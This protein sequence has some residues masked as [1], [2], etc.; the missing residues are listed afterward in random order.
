[1][2]TRSSS[3]R[4]NTYGDQN[5]EKA[6]MD[7]DIFE[8]DSS[9]SSQSAR[10]VSERSAYTNDGR[11]AYTNDASTM[12]SESVE[13]T[14]Y[15]SKDF[16]SSD[17]KLMAGKSSDSE[18]SESESAFKTIMGK[19]FTC[20]NTG[21]SKD[22]QTVNNDCD[23]DVSVFSA[24]S[25][26][27][28]HNQL[29]MMTDMSKKLDYSRGTTKLGRIND[30]DD[31]DDVTT[32]G[33]DDQDGTLDDIMSN[34]RVNREA[35]IIE[36]T[37]SEVSVS[38]TVSETMSESMP[39]VM[40]ERMQQMMPQTTAQ[41]VS[42][43]RMGKSE[44]IMVIFQDDSDDKVRMDEKCHTCVPDI[45]RKHN[46]QN[47]IKGDE[48]KEV[49]TP[50]VE[51]D[52]VHLFTASK[53]A[54]PL[55]KKLPSIEHPKQE[56]DTN[57]RIE[58][59]VEDSSPV[60][61][62]QKQK[63]ITCVKIEPEDYNP[64]VRRQKQRHVPSA[65]I[66]PE[67]IEDLTGNCED[68]EQ[69]KRDREEILKDIPF[70]KVDFD[71]QPSPLYRAIDTRSWKHAY[72][73]LR[74]SPKE[75]STW[76]YRRNEDISEYKWMFLPIHVAC[77]SGAPLDLVK[78][79]VRACPQGVRMAAN[80][81]KLPLHIACETLAHS[82]VITFLHRMYPEALYAIDESGNTPLQEAMFCE[83][84]S[85]RAR[86][87][88]LL[89]TLSDL[90]NRNNSDDENRTPVSKPTPAPKRSK[91]AFKMKRPVSLK[92]GTRSGL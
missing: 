7:L 78:R 70:E 28:S 16:E 73:I 49:I 65:K 42:Q 1:M 55:G 36:T 33:Y 75:A 27:S 85:G 12:Y 64:G 18:E 68:L 79:L 35:P 67:E 11:S 13:S 86:V 8:S 74:K 48:G 17:Q 31:G 4:G 56:Y 61:T 39:Q 40:P 84:K 24:S 2:K 41:T 51:P 25:K 53:R 59:E 88:K 52:K 57:R 82:S 3:T 15:R 69:E 38:D 60:L 21:I 76:V 29:D 9:Y 80:G 46:K 50:T 34:L 20:G 81:G 37:D 32:F 71:F 19:M 89:T 5:H 92:R 90:D 91:F 22:E 63:H 47:D 6:V 58:V 83:S 66:E 72:K 62:P 26:Y 10:S 45:D 44:E 77:F 87:M 23:D 54:E 30:D 43:D 14:V